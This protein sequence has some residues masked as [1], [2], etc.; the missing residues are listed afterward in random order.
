MN[1]ERNY[2]VGGI[3]A[4]LVLVLAIYFVARNNDNAEGVNATSTNSSTNATST[5]GIVLPYGRTTLGLGD[6]ATFRGISITP[7]RLVEDSRCAV[8][9]QCIQ[10]GTVRVS[11]ESEING[12]TRQDAVRLGAT[13]TID[14]FAVSL[15]SVSPE[16]RST[17]DIDD[18]DYRFTFEVRQSAVVDEE[19]IGK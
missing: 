6:T 16:A 10:A 17:V 3:I 5:G 4:L 1:N 13:T 18:E 11:V 15:V 2:V 19:L 8:D 12:T 7:K 14:T 9:V